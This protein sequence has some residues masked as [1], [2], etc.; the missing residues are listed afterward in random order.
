M[1]RVEELRFTKSWRSQEDFPTYE[2][3]EEQVR[4]DLQCLFDEIRD[5]LNRRMLPAV[6]TITASE[7]E[8][9]SGISVET[10]LSVLRRDLTGLVMG[11]LPDGGVTAEK[12]AP[13]SVTIGHL[14]P[15]ALGFREV[16]QQIQV[17][18]AAGGDM[19]SQQLRFYYSETLRAMFL[20]GAVTFDAK[21]EGAQYQKLRISSPSYPLG[22]MLL[23]ADR[24]ATFTFNSRAVFTPGGETGELDVICDSPLPTIPAGSVALHGFCLCGEVE[25]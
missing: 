22:Q 7:I 24:G 8:T 4:E 19:I 17:T 12:L 15:D 10:V 1:A 13:E 5:Y 11:Q 25:A 9:E 20:W 2:D 18:A 6:N 3:S 14:A 16:T 21:S 23:T